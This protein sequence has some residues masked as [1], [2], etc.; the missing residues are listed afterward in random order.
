[1]K[2][3]AMARVA[4]TRRN[5]EEVSVFLSRPDFIFTVSGSRMLRAERK[6]ANSTLDS[7]SPL[8]VVEK[9]LIDLDPTQKTINTTCLRST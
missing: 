7:S 5:G 1:M 8:L 6:I 3:K 9:P 2:M 4:G